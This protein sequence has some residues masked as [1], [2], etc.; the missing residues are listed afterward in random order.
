MKLS[1]RY[2]GSPIIAIE[3]SAADT[4][5]PVTRQRKRL[6]ALLEELSADE[7]N[8]PTRCEDW[9]V[10]DVVSH[11]V[12]VNGFWQ[13]STLAGLAGEPTRIL[14]NFDP[15]A[16][17]P[18]L[19]EPMRALDPKEVLDQFVSSNDGYLAV[20][21]EL[22]DTGWTT[23]AESPAGHVPIRLLAQHALWDCWIHERDIALPMGLT[24]PEEPD[25]VL[26]ALR[27]AAALSPAFAIST[28]DAATGTFVVE[29]TDPDSAFTMEIGESVTVRVG[30]A[31]D[32]APCLRGGAV[33]L[34]EALSIRAPLPDSTPTEWHEM[35]GGL[36]TAFS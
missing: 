20:I 12:S 8:A 25:E 28:G 1:P 33:E 29:T 32:A 21:A 19:V 5:M 23:L 17:P 11:M 18:L 30:N 9:T 10:Q 2:E 13:M 26:S 6:A 4:L 27:Y 3:G 14:E 35:L 31:P 22:D 15:A 34:L 24:P 16:T 7:W 36:T